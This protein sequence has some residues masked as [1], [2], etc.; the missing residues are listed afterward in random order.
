MFLWIERERG[1][2][3]MFMM[4]MMMLLLLFVFVIVDVLMMMM[5]VE[6]KKERK[7]YC[8]CCFLRDSYIWRGIPVGMGNVIGDIL[9]REREGW[10][11]FGWLF[12]AA[13]GFKIP[14]K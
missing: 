6:R 11:Q 9:E 12:W 3:H 4:M 2:V 7:G 10:K 8:D 5:M 13:R 14:L 1:L